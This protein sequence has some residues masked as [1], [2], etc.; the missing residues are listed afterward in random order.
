MKYPR[1]IV[2]LLITLLLSSLSV[3]AFGAVMVDADLQGVAV[4]LDGVY[5]GQAPQ[6]IQNITGGEHRIA[7]TVTGHPAQI[8][9]I[10]FSSAGAEP[11]HFVFGASSE[12][13]VPGQ[14]TIHD[15]V[16]TP[17]LTGLLGTAV[18]VTTRPDGSLMAYYSGLGDGIRCAGSRDGSVWYEYPDECLVPGSGVSPSSLFSSPWVFERS[19][20]GYRMI[21]G[22]SDREGPA[23]YSAIS[24]DGIRFTPEGRVTL[25]HASDSTSSPGDQFSIPSGIRITDGR[26]RM[27][28]AAA[29]GGIRSAIS[30]DDGLTWIDEE[31]TRLLSATDPS[32]ALLPD[33]KFGLFY[34][35]L[36]TGSKGQKLLLATSPDGIT[37]MTTSLGPL[38]ESKE[39][40]VWILDPD[41][42]I[43]KDGRSSLFFSLIGSP[44][45]AGIRTPIIM[46]SVIDIPCLMSGISG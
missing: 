46:K 44:G 29:G 7:A 25:T 10:T 36:S 8:K 11:V 41:M 20:G 5:I 45:E 35:D 30:S 19:D 37:F 6:E 23:L 2:L 4:F 24:E 39:K 1:L 9:N 22:S 16:G 15:C 32:V 27:Y 13:Y 3:G 18:T 33:G 28:Y 40:G 12:E 21:Y 38:I 34:V 14:I 26:L 43:T 17:S 31:G 42:H